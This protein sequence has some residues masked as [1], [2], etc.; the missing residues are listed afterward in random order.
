MTEGKNNTI[1]NRK[2]SY[3]N[4]KEYA[5]S[6][7]VDVHIINGY[8]SAHRAEFAGHIA[9]DK[10][11]AALDDWARNQLDVYIEN[12][13]DRGKRFHRF[14][15]KGEEMTL[16]E[17]LQDKGS[18]LLPKEVDEVLNRK[19]DYWIDT[20]IG[21][22]PIRDYV[23]SQA[24]QAGFDSYADLRKEGIGVGIKVSSLNL[25]EQE[26]AAFGG[27]EMG[28]DVPDIADGTDDRDTVVNNKPSKNPLKA[29]AVGGKHY[30]VFR[31][32]NDEIEDMVEKE[33]SDSGH[34]INETE[35]DSF[36]M[37]DFEFE[38]RDSLEK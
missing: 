36:D 28:V 10:N 7:N 5:G 1:D 34:K 8:I 32:E 13:P 33:K 22:M 12:R 4:I 24:S 6:K 20:N 9:K 11:A 35:I 31:Q 23:E 25:H 16:D 19:I 21:E 3:V 14:D 17:K 29:R 26:D 15:R 18:E 38:T 30:K 2:N 37:D 27:M